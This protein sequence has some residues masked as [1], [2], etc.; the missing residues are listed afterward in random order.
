MLIAFLTFKR[1]GYTT[2][3][4][5]SH[6]YLTTGF[7]FLIEYVIAYLFCD[8]YKITQFLQKLKKKNIGL[9]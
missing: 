2:E 9:V 7:F 1:R 4:G 5:I 6:I 8:T 3:S